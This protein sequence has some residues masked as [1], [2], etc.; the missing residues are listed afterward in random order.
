MTEEIP[1]PNE[2]ILAVKIPEEQREKIRAAAKL[3][4]RT[5]S[6]FARFHLIRAA[7]AALATT[8]TTN[9]GSE[10]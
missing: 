7:E 2:T 10:P 9:T 5:E 6:G 3:E 8:E 4:E 1:T